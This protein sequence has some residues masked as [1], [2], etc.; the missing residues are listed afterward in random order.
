MAVPCMLNEY[1]ADMFTN[2][3]SGHYTYPCMIVCLMCYVQV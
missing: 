3:D 2:L 1:T